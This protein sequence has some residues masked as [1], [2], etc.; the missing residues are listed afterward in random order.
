MSN[1]W[2]IPWAEDSIGAR[3]RFLSVR[4]GCG[5]STIAT[6]YAVAAALRGDHAAIFMFDETKA[7][8]LM[9]CQGIGIRINEGDGPGEIR[10]GR[11]ILRKC[12][13]ASS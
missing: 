3:V 5:K 4:P 2:T 1:R 9:R 7:A 13:R 6:Q 10:F 8:L 12:P 11:S